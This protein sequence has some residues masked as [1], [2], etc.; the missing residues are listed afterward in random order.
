[1]LSISTLDCLK[2]KES[3]GRRC[4]RISGSA[5]DAMGVTFGVSHVLVVGLRKESLFGCRVVDV[6]TESSARRGKG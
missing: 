4:G 5:E 6:G 3:C 2:R 1:M